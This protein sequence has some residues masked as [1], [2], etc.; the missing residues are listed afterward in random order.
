[1]RFP[2]SHDDFAAMARGEAARA[3]PARRG[4]AALQNDLFFFTIDN[5]LEGTRF[6]EGSA[7]FSA[8]DSARV[9]P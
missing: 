1:L 8:Q 9:T 4:G 5:G 7:R 2:R 6:I 3:N